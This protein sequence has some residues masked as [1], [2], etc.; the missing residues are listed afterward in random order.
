MHV[1]RTDTHIIS[2][3]FHIDHHYDDPAEAW[4]IEI[5]VIEQL[6]TLSYWLSKVVYCK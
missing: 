3:I 2:S 6:P 4:P 5:E 1:D